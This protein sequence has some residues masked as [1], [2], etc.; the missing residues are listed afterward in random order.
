MARNSTTQ[1]ELAETPLE[2]A[3]SL[4][5]KDELRMN[6]SKSV[7]EFGKSHVFPDHD[8]DDNPTRLGEL[9]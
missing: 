9:T 5:P 4:R 6:K 3:P 1:P 7:E 2:S 8:E